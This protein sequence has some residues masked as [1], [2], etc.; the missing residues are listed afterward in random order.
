MKE[1]KNRR[2]RE[3]QPRRIKIIAG[4]IIFLPIYNLL[5]MSYYYKISIIM[6]DKIFAQLT[7]TQIVFIFFSIPVGVGLLVVKRWV[8]FLFLGYTTSLILYNVY[9]ITQFPSK[10]NYFSLVETIFFSMIMFYFLR[11]DI[12][13]PYKSLATRGWR[14]NRR[15]QKEILIYI[16]NTTKTTKNISMSGF[17]LD[18]ENSNL[19][20]NDSMRIKIEKENKF[21]EI[22]VGVVRIDETGVGF[23]YRNLSDE[24]KKILREMI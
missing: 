10:Y 15:Y 3:K 9:G 12:Y 22:E 1:I 23:A 24:N 4:I 14:R 19:K 13:S 8:W 18:W 21:I 2:K 7:I 20:V 5:V 11:K 6:I 16:K 17:Y